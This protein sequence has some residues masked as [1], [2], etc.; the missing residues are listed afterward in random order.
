VNS[1]AAVVLAACEVKAAKLPKRSKLQA[2]LLAQA[3]DMCLYFSLSQ[4]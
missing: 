1:L 4:Q 3:D 2:P